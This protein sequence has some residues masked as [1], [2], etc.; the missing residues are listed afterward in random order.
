MNKAIV[1]IILSFYKQYPFYFFSSL[2]FM[3]LIPIND[4][5]LS[6][7]Y[8]VMFEKIQ[9]NTFK[10][11]HFTHIL[12]VIS[13]LQI[14]Y[15]LMDLND[16]KQIPLF[17]QKCKE[18]FL[19]KIFDDAKENFKEILTG[20]LL[21]KIIRAQH[22][23]TSWYSKFITF[24]IPH[25][26]EFTITLVYFTSI[27]ITLGVTFGSL[28][29]IFMV[30]LWLSP[31][32]TNEVTIKSDKALNTIHEHVDDMLNNYISI[33]KEDKLE[34]EI[35]IM[36]KLNQTFIRLY[37]ESVRVS[38]FYRIVL[39]V[40]LIGFLFK[41]THRSFVLLSTKQ[42][43]KPM[44]FALIMMLTNLIGNLLWMIDTTRDVI[45]DYG[46]IKNSDFL[47][48]TSVVKNIIEN[49]SDNT[50]KE[51]VLEMSNLFFKYDSA[52]NYTLKN[53]NLKIKRGEKYLILGEI[54]SG[55]TTLVK[56][57]LRL[58]KPEKGTLYLNGVCYNNFE[59]K[60]FFK[61]MGFMPQNC[62]LFNRSIVENIRYDNESITKGEIVDI[63]HK[64]GIMK[65]FSNLTNGIDSSAG[66]NGNNLS[67]GQRQLVWLLKIFFKR[68][69]IIIMDEPTA[70]L[71]KGTKDL[72]FDIVGKLLGDKTIII[73]T[74]DDDL[75][76]FTRNMIIVKNG[77]THLTLDRKDI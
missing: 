44:F 42:M 65:H 24:I 52:V 30:V 27:D 7:L 34:H 3:S 29:F 16:S 1:E 64:F 56:M 66:K 32:T 41:F 74:H 28:L 18:I 20:E 38:L 58:I 73:V 57:L 45:F 43:K 40:L 69:D 35:G 8:G 22:I 59:V 60:S 39:T 9:Q 70:S 21:S 4:I 17:Q 76:Q 15:A 2:I 54:G 25:I 67:G 12:G 51:N 47:R 23:I 6:K 26:F 13:F 49:C 63:L 5:Y 72:F 53:I 48:E 14:G 33:Y 11:S 71:D 50:D 75:L 36:R 31:K 19:K 10:M 61:K 37:N 62:V 68:P 46:T 77:E 55:K